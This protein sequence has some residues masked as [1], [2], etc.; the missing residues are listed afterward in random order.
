MNV[1]VF[2]VEG[3]GYDFVPTVLDRNVVDKWYKVGDKEAF[4]FSRRLIKEEGLLCGKIMT[5][6]YSFRYIHINL[7]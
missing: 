1:F 3:I 2:Q 6:I 5:D 7:Y 4:T